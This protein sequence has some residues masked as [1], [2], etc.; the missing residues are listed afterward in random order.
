MA[1]FFVHN[2][3]ENI[4]SSQ[5]IE[6]NLIYIITALLNEEINNIT[7]INN[8]DNFLDDTKCGI[9]LEQL[10]GKIDI[11]SFCKLNILNVIE[12]LENSFSSKAMIFDIENIRNNI[13]KIKQELE[14][15]T[16]IN[17]KNNEKNQNR[18]MKRRRK[19]S[20][21]DENVNI[22]SFK[23]FLS[24]VS[25]IL[26]N[27]KE[28]LRDKKSEEEF[29]LFSNKYLL[30]LSFKILQEKLNSKE[31]N[32]NI[33][34]YIKY[35]IEESKSIQNLSKKGDNNEIYSNY[36]F[37]ANLNASNMKTEI[38]PIYISSF[39]KA[40]EVIN[41]LFNNLLSNLHLIPYSIKCICKII[42]ILIKKKFPNINK[43]Q[44]NSFIAKFFFNKIL[45]PIFEN[46][47]HKG[48]INEYIISRE[49]INNI[50]IVIDIISQLNSGK[51]YTQNNK[52]GNFTPFNNFFLEILPDYLKFFDYITDTDL[53]L[54]LE[55]EI[56]N[57][58]LIKF[59]P[60]YFRD[61]PDEIIFHRSMLFCFDDFYVLMQNMDKSKDK[62]FINE[63]TKIIETI[64]NKINKSSNIKI[65]E[66]IK[67]NKTYDIPEINDIKNI[68]KK[69]NKNKEI[70]KIEI[71]KY[72]LFKK[73]LLNEKYSYIMD[74]IQEKP[75]YNI[76]ESDNIE[77]SEE[78]YKI[79]IIKVKNLIC[80]ILYNYQLLNNID[81]KKDI[82]TDSFNIFN[83]LNNY[84]KLSYFIINESLPVEWYINSLLEYLKK[85]PKNYS[86]NDFEQLYKELQQ[87]I[88]NSIKAL[89]FDILCSLLDKIKFAKRTKIYYQKE[90]KRLFEIYL[91]KKVQ[92]IIEFTKIQCE[93]YFCYN[94]KEK[95]IN[96]KE[97]KKLDKSLNFLDAMI[98]KEPPKGTKIC[99]T[100]KSFTENFPNIVKKAI[101]H[102]EN[103]KIFEMLKQLKIPKAIIKYLDI[104]K[105]NLHNMKLWS[106]EEE[107][108]NINNRIYD[109]VTEKIYDK[110]YPLVP[111]NRDI[112][113]YNN[114]CVKLSSWI[115]P[116]HFIKPKKNIYL[117]LFYQRQ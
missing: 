67:N 95:K 23:R 26:P 58:S 3:Y 66:N 97:V 69:K 70:K 93:L 34:E 81:F 73:L 106:T 47:L 82:I 55:K 116:K 76:K 39:L 9:F 54:F 32:E 88:N 5:Y 22:I 96:I 62:L 113:I 10:C 72:F 100:I 107:F 94:E 19:T 12:N 37:I 79:N 74:L 51:L 61:H 21:L 84:I 44:I 7:N 6:D 71:K 89:N 105:K 24:G 98:F 4:L 1:Q 63:N 11:K 60:S 56:N 77:K 108:N 46:P 59:K 57:N 99:Q 112:N 45:F 87:E 64:F 16:K 91:N 80:E 83:E 109:Y 8:S 110:I 65:I 2:F 117:I 68:S 78:V 14:N 36:S 18:K 85:I 92:A 20:N 50:K 42:S 52:K 43:S 25:S 48:L 102:E 38:M 29:N 27:E 86:E 40:I 49:T 115:E 111:T 13:N 41:V 104:V 33:K 30:D 17:N 35:Q 28:L 15:K 114:N 31:T 75:H 90:G 53:P 103:T 101:F